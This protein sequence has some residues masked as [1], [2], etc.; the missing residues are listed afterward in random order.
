[1]CY[2]NVEIPQLGILGHHSSLDSFKHYSIAINAIIKEI[3]S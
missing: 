3:N 2:T 1:M